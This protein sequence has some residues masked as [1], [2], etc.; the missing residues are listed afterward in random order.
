MYITIMNGKLKDF[1]RVVV[2]LPSSMTVYPTVTR[3]TLAKSLVKSFIC[4]LIY[5]KTYTN[6]FQ[7]LYKTF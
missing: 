6:N 5:F 2:G 1:Q 4:V 3:E 7:V